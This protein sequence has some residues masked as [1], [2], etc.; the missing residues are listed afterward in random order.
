[1]R[2]AAAVSGG[3]QHAKVL[4]RPEIHTRR[5]VIGALVL[6]AL[7]ASCGPAVSS[8]SGPRRFRVPTATEV[9][10]ID[11][12]GLGFVP[13]MRLFG[14]PND[15]PPVWVHWTDATHIPVVWPLGFYA[16]FDPSL[17]VRDADGRTVARLG[18]DVSTNS[19]VWP[20]FVVCASNVETRVWRVIAPRAT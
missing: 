10:G 3:L 16:V 12:A 15:D 14:D 11:C 6:A 4:K 2:V 9:P 18:D 1:M 13:P 8:E 19:G 5:W 7:A 20:G 17:E